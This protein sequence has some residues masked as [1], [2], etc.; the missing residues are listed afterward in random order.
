VA[1]TGDAVVAPTLL[2]DLLPDQGEQ[3][4]ARAVVYGDSAY[5]TGANLAR[6]AALG[7]R[8]TASGWQLQRA[9]SSGQ[10]TP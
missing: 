4:S 5:G 2:G 10:A 1:P 9:R 3:L 6:F 7:L 8:C